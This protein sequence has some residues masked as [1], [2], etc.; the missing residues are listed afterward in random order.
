M[1]SEPSTET[2][3][4]CCR[5]GLLPQVAQSPHGTEM[6]RSACEDEQE[7]EQEVPSCRSSQP[8]P[9]SPHTPA[10]PHPH[11]HPDLPSS[12]APTPTDCPVAEPLFLF[13][14]TMAATFR[15][16]DELNT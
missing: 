1:G 5:W 6:D 8:S 9:H 16:V 2:A 13:S 4:L 7:E 15:L 11:L 10:R 3:S 14:P 12:A